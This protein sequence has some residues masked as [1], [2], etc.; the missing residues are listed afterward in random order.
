MV[1]TLEKNDSFLKAYGRFESVGGQPR[2][3]VPLRKAAIARFMESG[4]P[5]TDDEE[6]RATDV[7]SIA[8]TDYVQAERLIDVRLSA[9][10]PFLWDDGTA[11]RLIFVNGMYSPSLSTLGELPN[12]VIVE[13]LSSALRASGGPIE[14]NLSRFTDD[15]SQAFAALNTAIF[16]DGAFV[17]VPRDCVLDRPIHVLHVTV[18]EAEPLAVHPRCLMVAEENAKLTIV[19]TYATLGSGV[20]FTNPLTELI[21][22]SGANADHYK[23]VRESN[24]AS[25]VGTVQLRQE[26]DSRVRSHCVTF[27]GGLVRHNINALLAG[28]G[29]DC[30]L[31][32]LYV[33][34]GTQH[35]DNHLRVEHAAP[36]CDS[37][38]MFKGILDDRSSGVFTGR[39]VVREGAVKTDGKQTNNNLLLSEHAK[40]DTKPQLEI[41]CD[42]V[43][44]T[45]GATI[46]QLDREAMFYLRSRGLP[47]N[48]ARNLLIQAFAAATL[49]DVSVVPLRRALH[50]LLLARLALH[51]NSK[52]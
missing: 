36:H 22:E 34:R 37:R 1:T 42:D 5:T 47:E 44:C 15:R 4:F 31:N 6:W 32:G 28:P 13:N 7:S 50:E 35:V 16:R 18:P 29:A 25:H 49:E 27:G 11:H 14:K 52:V 19:E 30:H 3:L 9:L 8:G 43:K 46:G 26:R 40:I 12:G 48:Q 21:A 10:K 41:F 51:R 38:E 24:E 23:I 33:L 17:Y 45:H 20:H 2:W 39:I